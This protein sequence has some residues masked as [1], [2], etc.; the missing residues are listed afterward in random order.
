MLDKLPSGLLG[1]RD[2][3]LITLLA[4]TRPTTCLSSHSC[5]ANWTTA[6]RLAGIDERAAAHAPDQK[7]PISAKAVHRMLD[8]LPAGCSVRAIAL[9]SRSGSR[10]ARGSE[11]VAL[12]LNAYG[13]RWVIACT[14]ARPLHTPRSL[15]LLLPSTATTSSSP[16]KAST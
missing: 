1:L 16:P 14:A 2:R 3:A 13:E 12:A 10:A 8:K 7:H 15:T 4:R 5:T 11:L 6:C 9:L